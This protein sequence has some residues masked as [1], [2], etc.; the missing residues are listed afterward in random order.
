LRLIPDAIIQE[1]IAQFRAGGKVGGHDRADLH[2]Q[3][4]KRVLDR[5]ASDYAS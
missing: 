2:F 5:S 4:L 3:A 1:T